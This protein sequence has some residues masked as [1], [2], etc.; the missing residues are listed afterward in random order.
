MNGKTTNT[1]NG[2]SVLHLEG[3]LILI[4]I[5]VATLA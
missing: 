4:A 5:N 1:R 3:A 2:V